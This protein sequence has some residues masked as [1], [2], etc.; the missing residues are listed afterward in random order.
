MSVQTQEGRITFAIEAFCIARKMSVRQ[1]AKTYNMP[2]TFLR[3]R[4][5]DRVA[6]TEIRSAMLKLTSFEKE[7]IVRHIFD[8]DFRRF[9]PRIND[10]EN[11]T[12]FFSTTRKAKNV[13]I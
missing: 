8:L 13:N 7:T 2:E 1:A 6:K 11:M 10:V 9:P 4:M 12:N 3:A 5:Q